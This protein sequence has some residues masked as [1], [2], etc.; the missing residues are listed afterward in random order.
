MDSVEIYT[1]EEDR[2]RK[3]TDLPHKIGDFAATLPFQ[4]TFIIAGGTDSK[5]IYKVLIHS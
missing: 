4:D 2:W 5:D 1:V 3:G